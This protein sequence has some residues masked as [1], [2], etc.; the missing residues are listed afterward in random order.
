LLRLCLRSAQIIYTGVLKTLFRAFRA[1]IKL[2]VALLR[3]MPYG[4]PTYRNTDTEGN[5]G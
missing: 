4:Y 3:L 1:S 5:G 2:T